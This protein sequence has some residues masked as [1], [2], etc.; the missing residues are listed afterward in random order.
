MIKRKKNIR[1]NQSDGEVEVEAGVEGEKAVGEARAEAE[2]D[3]RKK[4]KKGIIVFPDTQD[5]AFL[6]QAQARVYRGLVGGLQVLPTR[7]FP[8]TKAFSLN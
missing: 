5:Q 7:K 3:M 6:N 8:I 1:K 4:E 2:V